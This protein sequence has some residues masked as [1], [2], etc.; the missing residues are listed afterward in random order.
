MNFAYKLREQIDRDIFSQQD[1]QAL[2]SPMTEAA[3]YNGVSR[4][5]KSGDILKLKRG[6]YLFAKKLR[7]DSLSSF[8]IA[9]KLYAPSYVSFESALSYHG[10]IP[11]A[12]Y[13]TVSACWQRKSKVFENELGRFCFDYIPCRPFFMGVESLKEKGGALVAN[14][15]RALFD[16]LYLRR[17]KYSVLAELEEDLRLDIKSLGEEVQKFSIAEI[18]T[19]AL[20]YRRRNLT[21]FSRLLARSCK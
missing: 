13:S 20:S 21:E 11:E 3:I 10:L 17:K 5:L 14:P 9:N 4:A 8:L 6:L 1:L 18:E 12:V 2:L 16:L 7:R 19:L 15:L